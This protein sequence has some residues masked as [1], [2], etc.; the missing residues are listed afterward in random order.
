MES[1]YVPL[2]KSDEKLR[3][4][5]IITGGPPAPVLHTLT[6]TKKQETLTLTALKTIPFLAQ[7]LPKAHLI[8]PSICILQPM[9]VTP[10]VCIESGIQYT[11]L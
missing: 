1:L 5:K 10:R 9:G 11:E 6:G 7:K 3:A 8:R 2:S 4:H